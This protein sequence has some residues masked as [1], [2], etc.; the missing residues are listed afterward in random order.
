M[1]AASVEERP[2]PCEHVS[3][4]IKQLLESFDENVVVN[5]V[6]NGTE[7]QQTEQCDFT[8]ISSGINV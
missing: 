5:A 3:V 1:L 4:N 2:N 6:E 7:V 8:A